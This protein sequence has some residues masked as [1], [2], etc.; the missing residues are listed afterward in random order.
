MFLLFALLAPTAHAAEPPDR[1]TWSLT[2]NGRPVGERSLTLSREALGEVEL[3]TLQ[4]VTKVDASVLGVS[5]AY[6]Q[7]L[8]ANAD[9]GP[10]SFISVVDQG[11]A[12]AEIQGRKTWAGWTLTVTERGRSQTDELAANAVDLSTADLLDPESRVPLSRFTEAKLLFTETGDV[13]SGTVEPLGPSEVDVQGTAVPVE[14]YRWTSDT[15]SPKFG[16][17]AYYTAE[18]WLVRF[19]SRVFGQKVSGT[20]TEAP[21]RG[22]DDAPV[23]VFGPS[24]EAVEL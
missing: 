24:L 19:E 17:T 18:G 13:R 2:L 21:P 16:Y 22:A 1:L 11:G 5:L 8:T 4:A 3:R 14:G 10:A 7:K 6:Q 12:V 23:D 20:L 9:I 15:D